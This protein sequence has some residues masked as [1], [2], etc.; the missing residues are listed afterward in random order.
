MAKK[1]C[2]HLDE[3]GKILYDMDKAAPK[4]LSSMENTFISAALFCRDNTHLLSGANKTQQ[5][6]TES[7]CPL[8]VFFFEK[9]LFLRVVFRQPASGTGCNTIN[10]TL[11]YIPERGAGERICCAVRCAEADKK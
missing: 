2:Q 10:E 4:G 1:V 7:V 5:R 8:R 6:R 3:M 9:R 11:I